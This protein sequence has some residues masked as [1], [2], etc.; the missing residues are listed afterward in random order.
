MT[1]PSKTVRELT[2]RRDGYRCV[3]C[4]S[5][6]NLEWN[7]REAS[8]HGGRGKKAPVLTPADGLTLCTRDNSSLEAEGQTRGLELGYKI[9]RNRGRMGSHEIPYFD[10]NAR[11]WF[12]PTV[13]GE[14]L[15]IPEAAAF[16]L[17]EV[18]GNLR[19]RGI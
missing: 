4:G 13:T 6:H 19:E 11:R 17:L 12:L 10:Q 1:R 15:E 2:Y 7:H 18:A 8:G 14:R 5:P 16:E 3:D 9:R